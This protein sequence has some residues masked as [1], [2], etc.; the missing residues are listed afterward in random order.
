MDDHAS[1]QIPP[2]SAISVQHHVEEGLCG[3]SR[4][5]RR[6]TF[7]AWVP[8]EVGSPQYESLSVLVEGLNYRGMKG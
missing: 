2:F 6:A 5:V 3:L 1:W 7:L 8:F 4:E